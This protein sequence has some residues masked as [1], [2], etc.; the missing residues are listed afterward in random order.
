MTDRR[1]LPAEPGATPEQALAALAQRAGRAGIDWIQIREKDLNARALFTLTLEIVKRAGPARVLVN[2]RLDVAVAAGAAGV[3]LG[4]QSLP[5]GA[6]ARW[7]KQHAPAG[8]S[9][10]QSCH[11]IE[12][13]LAAESDGAGYV[14]FGPVFVTPSKLAYGPPQGIER[15]G[16]LCGRLKIPVIAIGGITAENAARCIDAGAAGVA[17]IRWFQQPGD[18]AARVAALRTA[19]G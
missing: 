6:V 10:G 14:I 18:L 13:A 8:F 12:Q 19:C 9:V 3:H 16:E 1:S 5:V 15:L 17:A 11:S 4:G 7:C 2:D